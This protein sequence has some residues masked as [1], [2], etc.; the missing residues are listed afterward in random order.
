MS[1]KWF[2]KYLFPF[3]P[4]IF[5]TEATLECQRAPNK[6]ARSEPVNYLFLVSF[7]FPGNPQNY[8]ESFPFLKGRSV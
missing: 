8:I 3:E 4:V 5:I 6:E 7:K 2:N 1:L